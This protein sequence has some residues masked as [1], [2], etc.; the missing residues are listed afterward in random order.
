MVDPAPVDAQ[1]WTPLHHAAA[2]GHAEVCELLVERGAPIT[3]LTASK[4]TPLHLAAKK[5]HRGCLER[6]IRALSTDDLAA[7]V[8]ESG[9]N[10][11]KEA[12]LMH[13]A[14]KVGNR[15]LVVA[16][17]DLRVSPQDKDPAGW[18]ALFHAAAEGHANVIQSL[19]GGS[20]ANVVAMDVSTRPA[21]RT[22]ALLEAA[23]RGQVH[24]FDMLVRRGSDP[25]KNVDHNGQGSLH[26]PPL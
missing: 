10:A 23:H 24:A 16:L 17:L 22:T 18:T 25:L 7:A 14:A 3:A 11:A 15:E 8:A 26:P 4:L 12:C 20:D 19:P 13:A 9:P 2:Q 6:L 1:K 21:T 5:G